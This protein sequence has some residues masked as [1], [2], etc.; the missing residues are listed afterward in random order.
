MAVMLLGWT[1]A[2]L[3]ANAWF[4][5][6]SEAED[7]ATMRHLLCNTIMW[8]LIQSA[9]GIILVCGVRFVSSASI[10]CCCVLTPRNMLF[11]LLFFVS[12]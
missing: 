2:A 6:H 5:S 4:I 12:R 9:F 8:Q 11:P 1:V 3:A 10:V 7:K